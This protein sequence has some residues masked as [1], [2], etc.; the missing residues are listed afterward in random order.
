MVAAAASS[1][2]A[3]DSMIGRQIGGYKIE[4]RIGS[5]GMGVVYQARHDKIVAKR[6]AIKVLHKEMSAD[7]K[8]VKRFFN[9]ANAISRAQHSSIVQVYD[10]GQL[11]DGTAY[12]MME[13]LEGEPLLTRI[14]SAQARG[15][16]LG[17]HLVVE[18][19]RQIA[20]ALAVTHSKNIVHRDLK[21]ENIFV[22]PDEVAPLGERVKLLDFGIAKVLEGETRKTTVGIILGTPLY[23]SPEQCEGRE[24]LDAKVDVYALGVMLFELRRA[25]AA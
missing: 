1:P 11:E 19:G 6:V 10:Y 22:V 16:G 5:G 25:V 14:E 3:A 21:P 13:M 8:L 24:D 2:A 20:T 23:M 12:I 15:T 7:A 4:R 9:E 17:L 18:L